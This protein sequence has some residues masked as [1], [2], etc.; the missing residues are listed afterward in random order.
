MT[1]NSP[2]RASNPHVGILAY[3]TK[4]ELLRV[5]DSTDAA[6]GFGNRFASFAV[7]RSELLPEGGRVPEVEVAALVA[8][9]RDALAYAR[10]RGEVRHDLRRLP[11]V[12]TA[13][14]GQVNLG[15]PQ[16]NIAAPA[17]GEGDAS[18]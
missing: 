13:G 17:R 18:P 8:R 5:F 12:F 7:R 9:T 10:T 14:A 16:V 15:A 6:N 2:M 11:A 4:D 3:I 1:R